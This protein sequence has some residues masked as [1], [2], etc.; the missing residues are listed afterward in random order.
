M[1]TIFGMLLVTLML[2]SCKGQTNN[3]NI[4]EAE[5]SKNKELVENL[6]HLIDSLY[7]VDQKVQT[8]I[9]QASQNGENE[10]VEKLFLE[11]KK[12]FN[13]HIPILKTIFK[14][15]GYPTNE[16]VGKQSSG[17]F[18]ILVQHSD[19]DVN[20]QEQMLKEITKELNKNNVSK[21]NYAYLTDRVQLAQGKSQVYGTQ[22]DYNT[23]IAQ[24]FPKNL[25]DSINVN[26]RRK[27]V[28]LE[29]IEEY[30]NKV[31]ETHFEMNKA[32]YDKIG[33]K[34]PKLYKTE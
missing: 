10:K 25:M 20:F 24:A 13:R 6:S 9:A 34:E 1:K 21:R 23:N 4:D 26:K 2:F 22:V 14:K 33:I 7:V 18:F 5:V 28:G 29:P 8:D 19:S 11:E 27:E 17:N 30:L 31:S 12:I 16:K 15:I 32:H 3:R